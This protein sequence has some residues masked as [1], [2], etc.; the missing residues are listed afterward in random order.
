MKALRKQIADFF[1]GKRIALLGLGKEGQSTWNLIRSYHPKLSIHVY[2]EKSEKPK[3]LKLDRNTTF[4]GY[5][6]FKKL[7]VGEYDLVLTSPGIPPRKLPASLVKGDIL[8]GQAELF[9]RWFGWQTI[10]ITGTKGKST[11]SSLTYHILKKAGFKVFL[12]GN[13]GVPLFDLIPKLSSNSYVVA[14]L[15]CHQLN[16]S[17]ASP[18]IGILLNLFVEHLDYYKS[19]EAYFHS[20]LPIF[21][22]Q[23]TEDTFIYNKDDRQIAKYLRKANTTHH[24]ISYSLAGNKADLQTLENTLSTSLLRGKDFIPISNLLGRINYY[25][26][27]PAIAVAAL[28]KI[29]KS[30]IRKH[31]QSFQPLSHRLEYLGKVNNILFVNDS[32]STIPEAT[33]AAVQALEHIGSLFLGGMDRGV[34][35]SHLV[36]FLKKKKIN[37]V[38]FFDQAG[39][40]M[41]REYKKQFPSQLAKLNHI[42]TSDF[43]EAIE[44]CLKHTPANTYCLLSPAAS[45][46]G[47]F[48]NFED[49]GDQFEKQILQLSKTKKFKK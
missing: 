30:E 22:Y 3:G 20:K 15:S 39:K 18:H 43:S 46:Y 35:Y 24:K 16:R 21:K 9:L 14:E 10:G 2:D 8:F 44:F 31:L 28:L 36:S 37:N 1:A 19:K 41:Y 32:I 7:N 40:R 45:S 29:N 38:V 33:Q 5:T 13:I 42:V 47:I 11:T 17:K 25:N 26:I 49:R 34:A 12:G 4:F 27:M 23:N 48:K 6:K